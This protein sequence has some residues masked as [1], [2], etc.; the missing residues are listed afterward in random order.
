MLPNAANPFINWP[1]TSVFKMDGTIA[2]FFLDLTK[3]ILT[4]KLSVTK[5]FYGFELYTT[6]FVSENVY[7]YVRIAKNREI[8]I[9]KGFLGDIELNFG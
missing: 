1:S 9:W 4:M 2:L 3:Y 6:C 5:S 8:E 7:L